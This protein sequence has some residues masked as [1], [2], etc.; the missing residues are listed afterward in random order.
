VEGHYPYSEDWEMQ[1]NAETAK[2]AEPHLPTAPSHLQAKE[3]E[4]V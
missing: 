4:L 1:A 2:S 3:N